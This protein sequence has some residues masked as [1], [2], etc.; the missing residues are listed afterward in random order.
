MTTSR[1]P[2][3][4]LD[5]SQVSPWAD[6]GPAG[7]NLRVEDF[8]TFIVGRLAAALQREVSSKYL[9]A[10]DLPLPQWRVLAALAAYTPMPFSELVR[11]SSS[12]KALVS[13]AV[14]ALVGRGLVLSDVDPGHGKK[15]ICRLTP[16]GRA[17][18]Q[19]VYLRGR[20]AQAR[21]LGRMAPDDRAQLHSL[22]VKLTGVVG[23][24]MP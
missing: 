20:E 10:F 5:D 8:P 6:P 4:G 15:I 22:L 1:A 13:R 21:L 9:Q 7:E 16:K 19:R 18:Y 14:Q 3:P 2:A 23:E 24:G 11:L 17:L 12:D